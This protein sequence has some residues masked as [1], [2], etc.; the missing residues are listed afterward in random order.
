MPTKGGTKGRPRQRRR[1]VARVPRDRTIVVNS[2]NAPD[3]DDD[4]D[5]TVAT[6]ITDR[7]LRAM[8]PPDRPRGKDKGNRLESVRP[9]AAV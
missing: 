5:I 3:D 1:V 9:M 4:E 7:T 2:Q 8:E 6:V